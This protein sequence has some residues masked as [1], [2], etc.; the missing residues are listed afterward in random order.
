MNELK[1]CPFCGSKAEPMRRVL[2]G[3]DYEPTDCEDNYD[4]RCTNEHCY[5]ADGADWWMELES[6]VNLWNTRK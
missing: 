2:F 3:F 1:P 4:I 5:L 6:V